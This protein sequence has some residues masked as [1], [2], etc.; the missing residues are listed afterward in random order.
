MT[1]SRDLSAVQSNLGVAI[2]PAAAGKNAIINGGFDIWQRGTA[3]TTTANAYL[4]DRW[5]KETATHYGMSR[6]TTSDTTNLPNIQYCMRVQ[7][8]AA[9]TNVN[10][11]AIGNSFENI[12]AT[13][14]VGQTITLSFWARKGAD[15]SASG[16]TLYGQVYY[17][18]G[19]DQNICGTYT[20]LTS[21]V[22]KT[23][24]L[25]TT[26]QR[27]QVSGTV[28]TSATELAVYFYGTPTGTAGTN[29]Y[30][31][32]T[33]VQL[34]L[35]SVA[36]PFSRNGSS[37]QGELA[38]CQRYYYR[39]TA[40]AAYG[41]VCGTGAG[42]TATTAYVINRQPVTMRTSPSSVEYAN[43]ATNDGSGAVAVT[44]V[45][46]SRANPDLT[47]LT[48]TTASGLTQ[49]RPYWIVGNNNTAG[50]LGFSAEL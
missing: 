20:G 40:T 44:A 5:S 48:I 29:D 10:N 1:R 45:A 24:T 46:I 12:N 13:P 28:S 23:A 42:A 38:A 17:G 49:Y 35:G 2:P 6:Q 4:A 41:T 21:V 14:F 9:S 16:S 26:W 31:E 50:Y 33:G 25:T 19:T 43:L 8:T 37:I 30:F 34:E 11:M 27:F 47:E 39:A 32:I 18:T 22:S 3:N 7:R 36:T 15:Y